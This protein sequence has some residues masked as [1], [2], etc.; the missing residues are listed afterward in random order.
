ML[1][2]SADIQSARL[3]DADVQWV[4]VVPAGAAEFALAEPESIV[5]H[6][7]TCWVGFLF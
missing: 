3:G 2:T 7:T 6:S 5:F 4:G 1:R